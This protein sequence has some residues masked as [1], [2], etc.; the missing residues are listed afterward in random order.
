[1]QLQNSLQAPGGNKQ[2][3]IFTATEAVV[4]YF[5]LWQKTTR[6]QLYFTPHSHCLTLS[7]FFS[8]PFLFAYPGFYSLT[9]FLNDNIYQSCVPAFP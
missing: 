5:Y 2:V 8:L 4:Q 9:A 6:H 1:M 7:T 3:E